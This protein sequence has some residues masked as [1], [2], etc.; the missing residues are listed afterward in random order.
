MEFKI[1]VQNLVDFVWVFRMD[2]FLKAHFMLA[3]RQIR[4]PFSIVMIIA[5]W[6][7]RDIGLNGQLL[8]PFAR[9]GMALAM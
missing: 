6:R 4:M 5:F 8:G 2:S 3:N 7:E 9:N 1:F